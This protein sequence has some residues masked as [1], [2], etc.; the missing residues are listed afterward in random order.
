[1]YIA[2]AIPWFVDFAFMAGHLYSD[3]ISHKN[4]AQQWDRALTYG[5]ADRE[6]G[7]R[8]YQH[9]KALRD[10]FFERF[11]IATYV[12]PVVPIG[13]PLLYLVFVW[14]IA[15]FHWPTTRARPDYIG[16]ADSA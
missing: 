4:S 16:G 11:R 5:G 14:V 15:G 7:A 8:L 12:L 9:H 3:Y 1:M 2:V 13:G 6:I 10:E